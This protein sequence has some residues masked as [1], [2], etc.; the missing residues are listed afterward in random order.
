MCVSGHHTWW[1][2]NVQVDQ[3]P[4]ESINYEPDINCF[5]FQNYNKGPVYSTKGSGEMPR[6]QAENV[7]LGFPNFVF[8][9]NLQHVYVNVN[10][11]HFLNFHHW[12][13]EKENQMPKS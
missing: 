13:K 1:I 3:P 8:K 9:D 10:I 12:D 2:F 6:W 4:Y 11:F 7:K 5:L